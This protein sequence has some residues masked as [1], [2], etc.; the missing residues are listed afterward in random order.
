MAKASR[1][2]SGVAPWR[3]SSWATDPPAVRQPDEQVLGGDVLVAH[4]RGELLGSV[5]RGERLAG[6][7]RRAH[8][9]A[10]RRRQPVATSC[11]SSPR[12][13]AASAPTA[14]S[15][16]AAMPSPWASSAPS[17]WVGPTSGLPGQ[18]G[19]LHGRG[20]RLLRLGGGVEGVHPSRPPARKSALVSPSPNVRKVESVPLMFLNADLR[21]VTVRAVGNTLAHHLQLGATLTRWYM[22]RAVPDQED[23]PSMTAEQLLA[24]DV[25][26]R[27]TSGRSGM[28]EI[29]RSS[30][31]RVDPAGRGP[32]TAFLRHAVQRRPR[33]RATSSR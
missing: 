33:R 19:G 25:A 17:R 4:L 20:D 9:G 5:E 23:R 30:F 7:L 15:S 28:V 27:R 18:R 26:E 12:T 24:A 2:A 6:Q 11:V 10:R 21:G 1:S 8:G 3:R 32:R 14:A 31:A 22:R 29:I 16:G 13:A